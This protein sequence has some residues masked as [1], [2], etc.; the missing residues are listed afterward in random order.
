MT[1]RGK[2]WGLVEPYEEV[3]VSCAC[4][5]DCAEERTGEVVEAKAQNFFEL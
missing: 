4:H 3:V 2:I 5:V 1:V